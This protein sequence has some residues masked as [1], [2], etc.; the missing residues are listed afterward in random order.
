MSTGSKWEESSGAK[1]KRMRVVVEECA[2]AGETG[3]W[4]ATGA[5]STPSDTSELFNDNWTKNQH[6]FSLMLLHHPYDER[7]LFPK[8]YY[9]NE[10]LPIYCIKH[11]MYNSLIKFSTCRKLYTIYSDL[12]VKSPLPRKSA[13]LKF[14]FLSMQE[15]KWKGRRWMIYWAVKPYNQLQISIRNLLRSWA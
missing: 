5:S 1:R 14:G 4:L 12:G 8:W 6:Y 3:W 7:Q 13:A 15:T 2:G 9:F 11:T 10:K